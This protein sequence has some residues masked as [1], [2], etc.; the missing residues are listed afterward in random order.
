MGTGCFKRGREGFIP[1]AYLS[2]GLVQVLHLFVPA[3][4]E[5]NSQ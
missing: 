4:G 3:I 5:V 2:A 1:W